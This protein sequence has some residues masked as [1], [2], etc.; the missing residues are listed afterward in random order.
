LISADC[1]N[2]IQLIEVKVFFLKILP[3]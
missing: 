3:Y 2:V 1:D